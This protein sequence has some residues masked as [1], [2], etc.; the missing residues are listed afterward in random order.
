M[1]RGGQRD[2]AGRPKKEG[3]TEYA[4]PQ[5]EDASR[6]TPLEFF[7]AV[8]R[9]SEAPFDVRYK[10]AQEAAPFVHAKLA[11]KEA[12]GDG[13]A[14]MADDWDKVLSPAAQEK[15]QAKAQGRKNGMH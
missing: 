9:D 2:G 5:I 15:A 13:Q 4:G 6:L 7:K 11:P 3:P 1:A 10:A 12:D 8:F 14:S